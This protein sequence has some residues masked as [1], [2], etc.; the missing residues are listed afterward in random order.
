MNDNFNILRLCCLIQDRD[1]QDLKRTVLSII[2]EILYEN[3]NSELSADILFQKTNEKFNTSLEKDF[4]DNLLI[5][6]NS[7][8]LLTTETA[9]LVKL[10]SDKF[11][12]IDKNVS[13]YSIEPHIENFLDQKKYPPEKKNIII[14]ILFQSIYENIYTFTPE[15]IKTIIP[16]NLSDKLEQTDLDIFNAFLE[17]D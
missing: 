4:F 13:D 3:N 8:E 17:F 16:Q 9:P 1:A 7:F 14:E 10:T 15:K 6:S 12:E 2:F 5:K 11:S